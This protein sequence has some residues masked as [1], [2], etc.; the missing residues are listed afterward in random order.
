MQNNQEELKKQK[1]L[2][3]LLSQSF[4]TQLM[5]AFKCGIDYGQLKEEEN[6]ESR[7]FFNAFAGYFHAQKT[8]MPI[9]DILGTTPPKS[10]AWLKAKKTS[11]AKF[12]ALYAAYLAQGK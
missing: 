7:G 1:E 9:Y 11:V 3:E 10:D 4:A 2:N 5:E 6:N 8:A 12:L